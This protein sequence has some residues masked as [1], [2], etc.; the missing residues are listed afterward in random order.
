MTRRSPAR[1]APLAAFAFLSACSDGGTTNGPP[2]PSRLEVAG[3]ASQTGVVR[4]ALPTAI[5]ARVVDT[6]GG[7]SSGLTVSFAAEGGGSFEPTTAT[8]DA[9][10]IASSVWTL[11]TTAGSQN[12]TLSAPNLSSI[13]VTATAIADVPA[14]VS[15]SV[16][17]VVL[18]QWALAQRNVPVV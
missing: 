18:D 5:Q 3:G 2:T 1:I 9:S 17:S 12:A 15:F 4:A 13:T 16:D 7:G 8:T 14:A 6:Q 10:G 11:G